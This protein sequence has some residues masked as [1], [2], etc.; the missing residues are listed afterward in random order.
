MKDMS[1]AEAA[2]AAG[3]NGSKQPWMIYQIYSLGITVAT[4]AVTLT[5]I[6]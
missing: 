1:P 3:K 5:A 6:Y 4:I 2:T